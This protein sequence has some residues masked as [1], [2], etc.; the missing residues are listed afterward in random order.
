MLKGEHREAFMKAERVELDGLDSMDTFEYVHYSQLPKGDGKENRINILPTHWRY[1]VKP[2]RL[3][4]RLVIDGSRESK[5]DYD[6][7]FAP[8]CR[9]VTFRLLLILALEKG[10]DVRQADVKQAFVNAKVEPG[11]DV[12]A[13]CAPGY[14]RKGMCMKL[15]RYA[16]GLRVSPLRWTQHFARWMLGTG[17]IDK[18]DLI[19]KMGFKQ[20]KIDECLFYNGSMY[21]CVYCDDILYTGPPADVDM[22]LL[23]LQQ[24]FAIHDLGEAGTYTGIQIER[25]EHTVSLHSKDYIVKILERFNMSNV[26]PSH[27]P[28]DLRLKLKIVKGAYTDKALHSMYRSKIGAL[29]PLSKNNVQW[30]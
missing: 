30:T 15:K 19:K 11:V 21:V 3:K 29:I 6:D 14:E 2:D 24:G 17:E 16:Y 22:F 9:A 8:V 28:M 12:Y 4:A 10:W 20:S 7:L 26:K 23:A 13:H 5:T 1:A 27:T 25:T 18:S